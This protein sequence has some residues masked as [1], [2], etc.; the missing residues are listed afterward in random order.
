MTHRYAD[1]EPEQEIL[2][3]PPDPTPAPDRTD[4]LPGVGAA[5]IAVGAALALMRYLPCPC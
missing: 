2:I 1:Q 5:L 3:V 4:R